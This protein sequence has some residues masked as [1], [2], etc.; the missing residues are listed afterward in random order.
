MRAAEVPVLRGAGVTLRRYRPEEYTD[1]VR[2]LEAQEWISPPSRDRL[3][4]RVRR[5]GMLWRGRVVL[6]IEAGGRLVGEIQTYRHRGMPP[7]QVGLGIMLFDEAD[8][9]RGVGSE[10]VRL[11][12]DWLFRS[13]TAT[14]VEAGTAPRNRAMRRVFERTGWRHVGTERAFGRTWAR[15]ERTAG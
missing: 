13:G 15:Y 8:R 6:A 4:R 2:A 14:R 1:A 12:V 11:L 3:R 7:R 5:S 9:G 10:A